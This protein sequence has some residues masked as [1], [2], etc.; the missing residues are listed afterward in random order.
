MFAHGLNGRR[1][2]IPQPDLIKPMG[3]NDR[4]FSAYGFRS[5]FLIGGI[6]RHYRPFRAGKGLL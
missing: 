3:E 2:L 4:P 6:T 1:K 5:I